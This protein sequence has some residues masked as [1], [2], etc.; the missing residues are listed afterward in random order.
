MTMD[1]TTPA[2]DFLQLITAR[3]LFNNDSRYYSGSEAGNSDELE[4]GAGASMGQPAR[5]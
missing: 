2:P 5:V 3:E 1:T 4:A